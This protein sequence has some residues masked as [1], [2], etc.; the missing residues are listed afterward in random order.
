MRVLIQSIICVLVEERYRAGIRVCAGVLFMCAL[1]RMCIYL[2]VASHTHTHTHTQQ[3]YIHTYAPKHSTTPH[4][5][6]IDHKQTRTVSAPVCGTAH[7]QHPVA[8]PKG[9]R[10]S[11]HR[12]GAVRGQHSGENLRQITSVKPACVCT[13]LCMYMPVLVCVQHQC[14]QHVCTT[15]YVLYFGMC[16][17][18]LSAHQMCNCTKKTCSVFLC[19][20][21][22][23]ACMDGCTRSIV[24]RVLKS[25]DHVYAVAALPRLCAR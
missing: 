25:K 20:Y 1:V 13:Y 4:L 7:R 2:C 23:C 8:Q 5:L 24:K 14:K 11:M 21:V 12:V 16:V 19:M 18:L 17:C 6:N 3:A 15:T 22:F 9:R 10:I